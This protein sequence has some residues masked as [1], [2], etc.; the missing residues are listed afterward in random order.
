MMER[1]L[2]AMPLHMLKRV[3]YVLHCFILTSAVTYYSS[4]VLKILNCLL[5]CS[6]HAEKYVRKGMLDWPEGAA[7]RESIRTV[8]KL[9]RLQV[10]FSFVL[11]PSLTL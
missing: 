2:G 4:C 10:T 11:H 6:R 5:G 7:S 1:V 3:E 8:L 9:P